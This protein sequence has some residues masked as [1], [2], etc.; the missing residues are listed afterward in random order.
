[1]EQTKRLR[2]DARYLHERRTRSEPL[3]DNMGNHNPSNDQSQDPKQAQK[4]GTPDQNQ[5][6]P[7]Q[8]EQQ[9]GQRNQDRNKDTDRSSQH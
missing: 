9:G 8:Q 7:G 2:C 3:E 6:R 4:K 1:M 5:T